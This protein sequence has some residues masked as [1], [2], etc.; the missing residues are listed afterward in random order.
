MQ[1]KTPIGKDRDQQTL[2][3][4]VCFLLLQDP[5]REAHNLLPAPVGPRLAFASAASL[6]CTVKH[7]YIYSLKNHQVLKRI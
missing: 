5:L 3:A 7:V 6:T 2:E 1:L 4:S